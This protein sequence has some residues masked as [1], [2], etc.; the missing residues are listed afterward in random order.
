MP[1]INRIT[2][3]KAPINIHGEFVRN[4]YYNNNTNVTIIKKYITV[5][6]SNGDSDDLITI[7]FSSAFFLNKD[8]GFV[9]QIFYTFNVEN[10]NYY[11]NTVN[12]E[13]IIYGIILIM[14]FGPPLTNLCIYG[15]D[16][17]IYDYNYIIYAGGI[18]ADI[19]EKALNYVVFKDNHLLD[20][21]KNKCSQI[22]FQ[23]MS[24]AFHN[25]N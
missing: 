24:K 10:S 3:T 1:D 20:I 16:M 15:T 2:I 13:K 18:Y 17:T 6:N 8:P 7:M 4:K 23:Y 25:H 14:R 12:N 22:A 21:K 9:K 11:L 5:T 19:L